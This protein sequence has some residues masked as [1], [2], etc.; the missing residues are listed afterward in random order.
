[1]AATY[2]VK[3]G[4]TLQSIAAEVY[5]DAAHWLDLANANNIFGP[6]VLS[7]GRVLTLPV[8]RLKTLHDDGLRVEITRG[9]PAPAASVPPVP[10]APRVAGFPLWPALAV[11]AVLLAVIL[12]ERR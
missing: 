5:G 11:G 6:A 12:F 10:V 2:T 8:V 4:D 3:A 9:V 7:V 1:M